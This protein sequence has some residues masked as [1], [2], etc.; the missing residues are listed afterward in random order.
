[1]FGF[2]SF[3]FKIIFASIIG[4]AL[5]YIPGESENSQNIVETSLICVF[6]ASIM[7]LTRQFSYEAEYFSMGFGI[8]AII[9]MI[10]SISKSLEFRK[11]IMWLFAAVIGM[12]IGSG[13]L[14]QACLLCALIYLILRNSK[15]LM[16]YIY[17][18]TDEISDSGI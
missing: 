3:A 9:I 14:I 13:F 4:G 17:K 7:G 1:M 5:N 16:G 11:Q 10:I 12:I 8:L 18:K 2:I 15:H 6:S